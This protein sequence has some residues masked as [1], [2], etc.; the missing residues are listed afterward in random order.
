MCESS[1]FKNSIPPQNRQ[2]I[3]LILLIDGC[4]GEFTFFNHL[5]DTLCDI[6]IAD[7]AQIPPTAR[8]ALLRRADRRPDRHR[9][10]GRKAQI[11]RPWASW[12][13]TSPPRVPLEPLLWLHCS[14][15]G[16]CL[17]EN[18]I[19][20]ESKP[21]TRDQPA[22]PP[23]VPATARCALLR[24]ADRARGGLLQRLLTQAA[25]ALVKERLRERWRGE[26][27]GVTESRFHC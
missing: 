14:I 26:S 12:A 21:E 3:V 7:P 16:R 15:A 17:L 25:Q 20:S 22:A 13:R 23:Q 10:G 1:G 19:G 24:R 6:K 2:L 27:A 5:H 4:V 9:R 11:M 8:R 18:V